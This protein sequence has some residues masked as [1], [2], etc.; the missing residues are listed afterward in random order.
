MARSPALVATAFRLVLAHPVRRHGQKSLKG[1][2]EILKSSQ[3]S[4][5]D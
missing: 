5:Y 3:T 4:I 2:S 1:A